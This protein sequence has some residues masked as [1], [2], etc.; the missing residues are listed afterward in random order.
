MHDP[1][2][3][4]ILFQ[5]ML[6]LLVFIKKNICISSIHEWSEWNWRWNICFAVLSAHPLG[7]IALLLILIFSAVYCL[8][9]STFNW[10]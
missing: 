8:F 10:K 7:W 3:Q 5:E 2:D 9:S 6:L 1:Y 4:S